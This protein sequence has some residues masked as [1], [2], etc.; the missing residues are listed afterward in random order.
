MLPST[1][2]I[3]NSAADLVSITLTCFFPL[4]SPAS[5]ASFACSTSLSSSAF[6]LESLRPLESDPTPG[7]SQRGSVQPSQSPV[8]EARKSDQREEGVE[9]RVGEDEEGE[10]TVEKGKVPHATQA[11]LRERALMVR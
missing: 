11:G 3:P 1:F 2:A 6:T 5:T 8:R 4:A 7:S 10:G 9:E